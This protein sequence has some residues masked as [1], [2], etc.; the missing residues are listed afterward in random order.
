[1]GLV[2]RSPTFLAQED[3][4]TVPWAAGTTEKNIIQH[5]LDIVV[6]IP[7]CLSRL[8]IFRRNVAGRGLSHAEMYCER[9]MLALWTSEIERRLHQWKRERADTYP[10]GEIFEELKPGN[11]GATETAKGKMAATTTNKDERE[12]EE[13]EGEEEEEDNFPVFRCVDLM[14]GLA[15]EPPNLVYPDVLLTESMCL[16]W[17]ALLVLAASDIRNPETAIA[18]H[19]RYTY[20]SNICRSI[21]YYYKTIPGPLVFRI[22][23]MMRVALDYFG[24]SSGEGRFLKEVYVYIGNKFNS[25]VFLNMASEIS[26]RTE[27]QVGI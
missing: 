7:S 14:T 23:T 12:E 27:I 1:M 8:D 16:Y 15:H 6:D 17:M 10:D 3:W 4:K 25:M 26:T 20:A 11:A 5:L 19:A 13:E 21:R 18:P 24:E 2:T 9:T 22:G